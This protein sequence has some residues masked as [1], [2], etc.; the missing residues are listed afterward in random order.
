[1]SR[2][3]RVIRLQTE[4][5]TIYWSAGLVNEAVTLNDAVGLL[6][7]PPGHVDRGGGQLAEVDEAGSTR[8]F[9]WRKGEESL[10]TAGSPHSTEA[11]HYMHPAAKLQC[12][13][14]DTSAYS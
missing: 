12:S 14:T 11:T 5:L 2:H 10:T 13:D 6:G 3:G 8:R 7:L 9:R 4:F 1:M